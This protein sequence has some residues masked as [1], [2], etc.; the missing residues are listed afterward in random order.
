[1]KYRVILPLLFS[2]LLFLISCNDGP[3]DI[4]ADLLSSD[5]V[6]LK[7]FD[8]SIDSVAQYSKSFKQVISLGLSSKILVGKYDNVEASGLMRF[9]YLLPDSINNDILEDSIDVL[10]SKITMNRVYQIGDSSSPMTFTVHK[11]NSYWTPF[12]FNI[13]SLSKLDYNS[14]NLA[15]NLTETDTTFYFNLDPT[16][17]TNLLKFSAGD[18]NATDFGI[19]LK[20]ETSSEKVVGFQ[21]A[22][23]TT[24]KQS[25][26][27]AVIQKPGSYTDTIYAIIVA[28]N[29]LVDGDIPAVPSDDIV[30]KSGI[31]VNSFIAFDFSSFPKGT[32][33]NSAELIFTED[34]LSG[35]KGNSFSNTLKV[36]FVKDSSEL[37][38][39]NASEIVLTKTGDKFSH[40]ISSYVREWAFRENNKGIIIRPGNQYEGLE[41]FVLKGSNAPDI[42][43]RPRVKIIYSVLKGL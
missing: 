18:E 21:A 2:I 26:L 20:P 23:S 35:T 12:D 11:V 32:V 7:T 43:A 10:E 39:E 30:V 29:S 33:I 15:T 4:G 28:D 38:V 13:D 1:L 40:D 41:S 19:Y 9:V 31:S 5:N 34:T 6:V 36:Y 3:A 27:E 37:T 42:N 24:S 8:T 16:L 25:V 17:V 14:E 22:T